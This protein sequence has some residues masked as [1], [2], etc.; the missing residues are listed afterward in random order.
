[1]FI[2]LCDQGRKDFRI[3]S[4]LLMW[5]LSINNT[6]QKICKKKALNCIC[7][8]NTKEN[9]CEMKYFFWDFFIMSV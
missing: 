7:K 1:M 9:L 5:E 3:V 2:D 8:L 6:K 4:I